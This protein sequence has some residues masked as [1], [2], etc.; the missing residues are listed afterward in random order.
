MPRISRAIA[1]GYPHHVTQRG[2]YRQTVFSDAAD[3]AKYLDYLSQY[4]PQCD[5]EIWTNPGRGAGRG[6]NR[7]LSLF[8]F[9][10]Y[11]REYADMSFDR[12]V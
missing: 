1:A 5:L 11:W 10:Y 8:N 3:Y 2:D 7:F 9:P 12:P 6:L 4:A